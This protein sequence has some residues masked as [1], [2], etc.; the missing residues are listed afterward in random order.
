MHFLSDI[1][2]LDSLPESKP[3]I[4]KIVGYSWEIETKYYAAE[5]LLCVTKHRTIGDQDFADRLEGF[6]VYFDAEEV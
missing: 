5:T 3:V 4:E 6:V 2:E 1:L